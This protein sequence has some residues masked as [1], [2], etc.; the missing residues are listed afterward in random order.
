M[1]ESSVGRR[2]YGWK[3]LQATIPT[4]AFGD[5]NFSN[6]PVFISTDR[7]D[8]VVLSL[9][10]LDE[11]VCINALLNDLTSTYVYGSRN[12]SAVVEP[13]P[14]LLLCLYRRGQPQAPA[15][16]GVEEVSSSGRRA[17]P[18]SAARARPGSLQS[19]SWLPALGGTA[20]P[21]KTARPRHCSAHKNKTERPGGGGAS[22]RRQEGWRAARETPC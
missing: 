1:D 2:M 3:R 22:R 9:L 14:V 20:P 7:A 21:R 17:S 15:R 11:S 6:S 16:E 8:T 5:V 18:T 4:L 19:G 13:S 12:R 10:P